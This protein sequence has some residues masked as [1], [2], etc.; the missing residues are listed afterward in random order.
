MKRA[1]IKLLASVVFLVA[2][3]TTIGKTNHE[4]WLTAWFLLFIFVGLPIFILAWIDLG[5]VLRSVERPSYVVRVLGL[6]FGAPQ[7]LF[8][9]VSI[10]LGVSLIGWV[11]YNSFI[12]TQPQYSGGFLTFGI[13]PALVLF[14]A[15]W[16][17]AAFRKGTVTNESPTA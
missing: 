15:Y 7:A 16:V 12:Q 1:S 11:L 8:G 14:G 17:R 2:L 5:K 10:V 4:G 13:G 3:A 6:V 9:L